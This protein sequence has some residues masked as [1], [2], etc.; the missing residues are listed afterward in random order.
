MPGQRHR[1]SVVM[2]FTQDYHD[3]LLTDMGLDPR[4]KVRQRRA[5]AWFGRHNLLKSFMHAPP[6]RLRA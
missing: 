6:S 1:G 5:N 2:L 4:R 3:Q